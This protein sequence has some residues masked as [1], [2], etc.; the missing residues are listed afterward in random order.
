[1]I[2]KKDNR[3]QSYYENCLFF[4]SGRN[5]N[6]QILMGW[7][8]KSCGSVG[9]KMPASAHGGG[10]LILLLAS[11]A[12]ITLAMREEPT[13]ASWL[14]LPPSACLD[15]QLCRESLETWIKIH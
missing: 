5:W 15:S 11:S 8:L 1:M 13:L 6:E 12:D 3:S 9:D 14:D 7:V 4:G 2:S 10:P